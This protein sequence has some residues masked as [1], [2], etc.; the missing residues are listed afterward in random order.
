[1]S[2]GQEQCAAKCREAARALAGDS[3]RAGSSAYLRHERLNPDDKAIIADQLKSVIAADRFRLSPRIKS[4][5]AAGEA[6]AA[7]AA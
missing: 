6:G 2:G 1:M 7:T 4:L 5:K 3:T